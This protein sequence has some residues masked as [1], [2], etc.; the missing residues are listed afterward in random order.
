M[1]WRIHIGGKKTRIHTPDTLLSN[2]PFSMTFYEERPQ[3]SA[4]HDTTALIWD[5]TSK[6]LF[7]KLHEDKEAG[8]ELTKPVWCRGIEVHHEGSLFSLPQKLKVST[9][10]TLQA[11]IEEYHQIKKAK[12]A[13][14]DAPHGTWEVKSTITGR[15]V[16]VNIEK[17]QR[18]TEKDCL[19]IVEAMKMENKIFAPCAGEIICVE[20]QEGEGIATGKVLCVI[21]KTD[22]PTE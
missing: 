17:G 5:E 9:P 4:A 16:Q 10:H 18:V 21:K 2:T 12:R 8:L 19:F 11:Q 1:Q 14:H 20:A 15:V 22:T 3:A 7:Y 6:T 13:T